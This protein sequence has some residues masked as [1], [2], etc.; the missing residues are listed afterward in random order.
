MNKNRKSQK[1]AN[2]SHFSSSSNNQFP[3]TMTSG[4]VTCNASLQQDHACRSYCGHVQSPSTTWRRFSVSFAT[5]NVSG[6]LEGAQLMRIQPAIVMVKTI[7]RERLNSGQFRSCCA[8]Y[9]QKVVRVDLPVPG[10]AQRKPPYAAADLP[11]VR[12]PTCAA[13]VYVH[14]QSLRSGTVPVSSAHSPLIQFSRR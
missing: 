6:A 10:G 2:S 4:A 3:S 14:F 12:P 7:H 13:T 8:R 1:D 5:S 11:S 9:S